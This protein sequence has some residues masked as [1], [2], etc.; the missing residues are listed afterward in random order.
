MQLQILYLGFNYG[1][2]VCHKLSYP[3]LNLA[4]R[5]MSEVGPHKLDA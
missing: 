4:V 3:R 1:R 5:E 2:L